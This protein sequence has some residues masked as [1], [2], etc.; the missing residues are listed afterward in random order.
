MTFSLSSLLRTVLASTTLLALS[1]QGALASQAALH[2][3]DMATNESGFKIERKVSPTGTY[4]QL[5]LTAANLATFVDPTLAASTTYCYRVRAY[6]S[7]GNSAYSNEV[8]VTTPVTTFRLS[9][10]LLGNGTLTGTG[11]NCPTDCTE[12]YRAGTSVTLTPRAGSGAQFV[13]WGGACTG[14]G[15]T[16]VVT[17]TATTNVAA[18][19]QAAPTSTPPQIRLTWVDT[20]TTERGFKV[21]RKVNPTGTYTQLALT[22][23][24]TSAFVDPNL[25]ASTTYCYRVRAYNTAGDSGYST[26]LCG[27][28][29]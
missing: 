3:V 25:A 27:T 13:S 18:T 29:R 7:A 21:E 28:T 10:S 4:A 2:W 23:A 15:S 12:D 6:N 19:F 1:V 22:A 8:C 26:E 9:A 20:A 16:C 11:I 17:I 14:Q 5:A 24:N